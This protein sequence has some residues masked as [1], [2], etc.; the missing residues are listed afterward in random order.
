MPTTTLTLVPTVLYAVSVLYCIQS[1][2]HLAKWKSL[3]WGVSVG[4]ICITTLALFYII[5]SSISFNQDGAV[6]ASSCGG[7]CECMCFAEA[8]DVNASEVACIMGSRDSP[9]CKNRCRRL[10]RGNGQYQISA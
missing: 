10:C 1:P 3:L 4:M 9:D 7:G 2:T 5:I 8:T 6:G